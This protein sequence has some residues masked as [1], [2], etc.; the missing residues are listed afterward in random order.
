M[1]YPTCHT[2]NMIAVLEPESKTRDSPRLYKYGHRYSSSQKFSKGDSHFCLLFTGALK[3]ITLGIW[4][5][6]LLLLN[7][8]SAIQFEIIKRNALLP[9]TSILACLHPVPHKQHCNS[10][11]ANYSPKGCTKYSSQRLK[12]SWWCCARAVP[13]SSGGGQCSATCRTPKVSKDLLLIFCLSADIF[14]ISNTLYKRGGHFR[15]YP[16]ALFTKV[17]QATN[18]L[19]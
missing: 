13:T 1:T 17:S 9:I 16:M 11:S 12:L 4:Y 14:P 8:N 19:D 2:Y 7:D 3:V 5:F 10:G 18:Y 6:C 15:A